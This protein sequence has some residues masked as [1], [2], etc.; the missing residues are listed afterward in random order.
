MGAGG[1]CSGEW[2][3][4]HTDQRK[5]DTEVAVHESVVELVGARTWEGGHGFLG[6][7]LTSS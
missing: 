2:V 5:R 7:H 6:Q 4:A 3:T 1:P